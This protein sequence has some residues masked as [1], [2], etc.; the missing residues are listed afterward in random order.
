MQRLI[1]DRNRILKTYYK[2]FAKY[3]QETKG[4]LRKELVAD[5]AA[6]LS[7]MSNFNVNNLPAANINAAFGFGNQLEPMPV[8]MFDDE[9]YE[10]INE[11]LD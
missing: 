5:V 1:S 3:T 2:F 4:K 11:Q 7:L 9:Q 8:D 6:F 10:E